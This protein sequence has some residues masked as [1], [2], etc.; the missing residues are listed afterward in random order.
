MVVLI[1]VAQNVTLFDEIVRKISQ[2]RLGVL[3]AVLPASTWVAATA[4][5]AAAQ[6]ALVRVQG[7]GLARLTGPL[8]AGGSFEDF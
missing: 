3:Q 1:F 4:L 7:A 6:A 5:R 2:A 8:A